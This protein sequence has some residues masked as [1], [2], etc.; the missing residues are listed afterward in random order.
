MCALV[1]EVC[2]PAMQGYYSTLAVHEAFLYCFDFTLIVLCFIIFSV[3]HFGFYLGR[4]AFKPLCPA[5]TAPSGAIHP[6]PG[7]PTQIPLQAI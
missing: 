5:S 4:T 6:D 2:V 7:T 1:A 3:W